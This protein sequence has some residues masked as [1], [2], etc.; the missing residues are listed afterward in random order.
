M[1]EGELGCEGNKVREGEKGSER[2]LR[3][4]L[5]PSDGLGHNTQTRPIMVFFFILSKVRVKKS[6]R[7]KERE[8]E[9]GKER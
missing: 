8:K 5:S 3:T 7:E 4:N 9:K 1:R 2:G 6:D